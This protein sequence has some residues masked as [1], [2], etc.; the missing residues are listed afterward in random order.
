MSEEFPRMIVLAGPNGSG[1][2]TVTGGLM[3]APEFPALYINA[4]DISRTELGHIRDESA[5]NLEAANLAEA[6]RRS[7]IEN[8][9]A[10]AFETVLSTP[11]KLA[12]FD[13]ARANN[14]SVELIFVTTSDPS[15][16]RERVSLRVAKGGHY[17]DPEKIG[18]RYERAMRLLPSAV[19]KADY[20]EVFDNSSSDGPPV[21]VAL[22]VGEHL[23]YDDNGLSWVRMRMV[24][25]F[26]ARSASRD[27]LCAALDQRVPGATVTDATIAFGQQY[28]GVVEGVT[29]HHVLQATE[30]KGFVMHDRALC[31]ATQTFIIGQASTI[32]YAFGPDGKHVLAPAHK[33]GYR[34]RPG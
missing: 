25:P 8:G 12:L 34:H 21:L 19:S 18:E 20:A 32:S 30:G 3:Q 15:I 6:R 24:E 4:D 14:F 29:D 1:K 2:S 31:P 16:N 23:D 7:A 27:K 9:H 11:G 33:T 10:F 13:E 28:Y 22:K 17:V 5:R 26:A